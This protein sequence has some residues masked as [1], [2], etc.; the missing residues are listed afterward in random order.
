MCGSDINNAFLSTLCPPFTVCFSI[1]KVDSCEKAP[2]TADDGE[3]AYFY[4]TP[5]NRVCKGFGFG[6]NMNKHEFDGE[7]GLEH[8]GEDDVVSAYYAAA[9][10]VRVY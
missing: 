9:V 2:C 8:V 6:H 3:Y 5:K 4:K 7:E 10:V 1:W